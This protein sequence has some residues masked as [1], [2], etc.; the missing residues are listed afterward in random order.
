MSP[1][2]TKQTKIR[3]T[4][5][6]HQLAVSACPDRHLA[7]WLRDMALAGGQRSRLRRSAKADPALL[8]QL[9]KIGNNLN[10]SARRLNIRNDLS[11]TERTFLFRN[12]A[13]I[14]ADLN[15]IRDLVENPS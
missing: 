15:A 3:W 9:S 14:E 10:Q 5:A 2:R 13:S 7:S 4:D 11:Q 6:E 8:L 12:L 1:N